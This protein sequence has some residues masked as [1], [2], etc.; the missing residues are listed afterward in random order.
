MIRKIAFTVLLSIL[1]LPAAALAGEDWKRFEFEPNGNKF[2]SRET[3]FDLFGSLKVSD[4]EDLADGRL[5]V[6]LGVN[7]FFNRFLGVG[8]DT[9][10]E[11]VDWPDH[12]NG[13]V[14]GR[15]PVEQW[16]LAPYAVLGFGRQF[17]ETPQWTFH[18]G[19]GVDYRFNRKTGL[20]LDVRQTVADVSRDFVLFR[21]GVRLGF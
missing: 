5:G 20:F 19:G 4:D 12:F 11:E 18:F 7:H 17:H 1:L 15:Y 21:F 16:G 10:L 9:R 14:I 2:A 8:A 3:T 13:S 6:G